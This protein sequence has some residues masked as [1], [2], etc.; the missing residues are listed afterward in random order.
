M[1]MWASGKQ[2]VSASSQV[3]LG[4]VISFRTQRI[5]QDRC[6]NTKFTNRITDTT[7]ECRVVSCRSAPREEVASVDTLD[8]PEDE[9]RD[10]IR[11]GHSMKDTIKIG[12]RGACQYVVDHIKKRWNTSKVR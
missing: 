1:T 11:Q 4:K 6:F 12:R 8:I 10:L 5:E 7:Q 2:V 3:L 9:L